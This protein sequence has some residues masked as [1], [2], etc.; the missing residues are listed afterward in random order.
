LKDTSQSARRVPVIGLLGG[1]ASG[2]S[3]VAKQLAELGAVVLDGDQAGHEVLR[4][5]DVKAALRQRWGEKAFNEDDEIDRRAV[6]KLVF[7]DSP[8]GHREL[9]FLEQVTHPRIMERLKSQMAQAAAAGAPA[10][11]LDAAVMLKGGWDRLCDTVWFVDTP[12]E[13]RL[14]RARLRGWSEQ[15]FNAREAMQEGIEEKRR[16]ADRVI[17]NAGSMDHAAQQ[18]RGLWL[19]LVAGSQ[20]KPAK[21]RL[22]S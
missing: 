2:K 5:A 16:R 9:K 22:G 19:E 12:R 18:V 13:V 1:V 10:V 17:D 21:R 8:A 14:E 11:V 7:A 3:F 6:G 15:E 20:R 4:E